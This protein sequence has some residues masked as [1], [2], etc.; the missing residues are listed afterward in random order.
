MCVYLQS[1]WTQANQSCSAQLGKSASL[2][3]FETKQ[4][5]LDFQKMLENY[6]KRKY[7]YINIMF[8]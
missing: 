3:A 7:Q 6:G 4:E 5:Y 1:T 2:A 8:Y